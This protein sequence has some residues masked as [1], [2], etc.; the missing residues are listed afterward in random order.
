MGFNLFAFSWNFEISGHTDDQD[1][2]DHNK[3]IIGKYKAQAVCNWLMKKGI[4]AIKL[5]YVGHRTEKPRA[6]NNTENGK[7]KNMSSN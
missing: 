3:K 5:T 2:S 1:S 7:I 6:D 4:D